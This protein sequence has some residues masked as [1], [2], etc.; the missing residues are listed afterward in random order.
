MALPSVQWGRVLDMSLHQLVV[1]IYLGV[2]A[3][4]LGFFLF[5]AGARRTDIGTLAVFNNLKIPLAILASGLVFREA[6]DWPRLAL[7]VAVIAC[8]LGL[9][10][11]AGTPS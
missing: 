7:G 4:G 11:L 10:G 9:N 1:L 8:A 2:V 3:S 6:V 5:N